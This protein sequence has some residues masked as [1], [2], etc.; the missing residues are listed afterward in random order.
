MTDHK[1]SSRPLPVNLRGL[2]L[3]IVLV[4]IMA[5]LC[6]SLVVAYRV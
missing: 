5:T 4:S 6:N 1:K 3:F 2:I